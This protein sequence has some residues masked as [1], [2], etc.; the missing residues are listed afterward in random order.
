MGHPAAPDVRHRRAAR[1]RRAADPARDGHGRRRCAQCLVEQFDRQIDKGYTLPVP[2]GLG[3]AREQVA[4]GPLRARR[5]D[6][7]RRRGQRPAAAG[8]ARRPRR[9]P[10]R[11]RPAARL[12]G[13]ARP[14]APACSR[15]ARPTSGSGRSR[16]PAAATSPPSSTAC[17]RSSR[18]TRPVRAARGRRPRPPRGRGGV[19]ARGRTPST[20][21]STAHEP[22][23]R[24]AAPRPARPPRARPPGAPHHGRARRAAAGGRPVAQ[25]CSASAPAWSA[26]SAS[27]DGPVGRRCAPTSTRCRCR[28]PRTCRT[29]RR[30]PGS[31]PRLRPRRA[32]QRGARRRRSRSA[33]PAAARAGCGCS[34]SRPRSSCPA[35]RSTWSPRAGLDDAGGGLRPALRPLPRG[36][37]G[38]PARAV[39]SPRPPTP[40]GSGCPARAGTRRAR[41]DRRPGVRARHGRRPGLPDV[42]GAPR[43]PAGRP[44]PGLGRTS[45]PG[46]RPTPSRSEGLLRGHACA[47]STGVPGRAR[48]SWSG[49]S[50][51]AW[52]RRTARSPT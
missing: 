36:R 4:G 29:A 1:R 10:A 5:R 49:G 33:S 6:H 35:A 45:P 28:T 8:R 20:A 44:V 30:T 48:R 41:T 3:A 31:L 18:R 12:R 43:R 46:P 7:P 23:P 16:P 27:G 13:R 37:P 25:A 52:W 22:R 34:S 14:G 9:R 40:C 26:T 39:R 17:S 21:G 19:T 2:Q 32:H 51:R 15:R 47:C 24:R 11:R 42:L 38:R 50:S